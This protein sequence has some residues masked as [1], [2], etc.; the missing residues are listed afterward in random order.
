MR[1]VSKA[2]TSVERVGLRSTEKWCNDFCFGPRG[3]RSLAWWAGVSSTELVRD[4]DRAPH[5]E[6]EHHGSTPGTRIETLSTR[7]FTQNFGCTSNAGRREYRGDGVAAMLGSNWRRA[8]Q[9]RRKQHSVAQSVRACSSGHSNG[10]ADSVAAYHGRSAAYH[11]KR[12]PMMR[13]QRGLTPSKRRGGRAQRGPI[14]RDKKTLEEIFDGRTACSTRTRASSGVWACQTRGL[15][16]GMGRRWGTADVAH[17][18]SDN[19]HVTPYVLC[20]GKNKCNSESVN[21]IIS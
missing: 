1:C 3:S 11:A 9:G 14:L 8:R 19:R 18:L 4:E 6:A 15:H 12:P 5:A 16:R 7:I 10:I 21:Y 17:E 13:S 2:S 20:M